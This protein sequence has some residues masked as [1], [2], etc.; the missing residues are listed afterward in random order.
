MDRHPLLSQSFGPM[1]LILAVAVVGLACSGG[2]KSGKYDPSKDSQAQAGPEERLPPPPPLGPDQSTA[3]AS[4]CSDSENPSEQDTVKFPPLV[5]GSRRPSATEVQLG[6][7]PAGVWVSHNLTHACCTKAK[8]YVQ[9]LPGQVNFFETVEGTPCGDGCM[10]TSQV[11]AAAGIPPGRY[12]V[13]LRLEDSAGS[14]IVKQ[15]AFFVEAY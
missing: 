12:T 5:P 8:V 4:G 3:R 6:Q 1:R 7:Q 14:S 9:R 2:G 15:N 11:Y 13:A 10:C